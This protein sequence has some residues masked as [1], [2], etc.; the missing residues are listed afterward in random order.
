MSKE[1]PHSSEMIDTKTLNH[2]TLAV[3]LFEYTEVWKLFQCVCEKIGE[4]L[5]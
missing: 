1:V 5:K 3:T 4:Q 2:V